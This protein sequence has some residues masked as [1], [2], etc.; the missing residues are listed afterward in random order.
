VVKL[1]DAVSEEVA[2][3]YRRMAGGEA[4]RD[5]DARPCVDWSSRSN[6]GSTHGPHPPESRR[7]TDD[8]QQHCNITAVLQPDYLSR[9]KTCPR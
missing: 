9:T 8:E 2:R 4:S 1:A 6:L 7:E 3:P 5:A